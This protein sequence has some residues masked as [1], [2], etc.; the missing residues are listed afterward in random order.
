MEV[1]MCFSNT[2][3]EREKGEKKKNVVIK[4]NCL[5]DFLLIFSA[6]TQAGWLYFS[7]VS[8]YLSACAC[9]IESKFV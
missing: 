4:K 3:I 5:V 7:L 2:L 6:K 9:L 1:Q 8:T